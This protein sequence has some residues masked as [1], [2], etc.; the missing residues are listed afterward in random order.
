MAQINFKRGAIKPSQCI[1]D[2][3][4]IIK[5]DYGMYFGI[6][7][8][9]SLLTG[10][11]PI[12]NLFLI[13]PV[14][15]GVFYCFLRRMRGEYVS[16]GDMFKGFDK[17]VPLMLVGLIQSIPGVIVQILQTTTDLAQT[18]INNRGANNGSVF[19]QSSGAGEAALASTLR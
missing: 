1:A 18:F 12:L 3:W 7:L 9:A 11:I 8:V 2:G 5:N 17:F 14:M 16:F 4:Q 15:G 10:C 19:F 13:G 6:V